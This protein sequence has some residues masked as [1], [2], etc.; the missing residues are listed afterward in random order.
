MNV[1]LGGGKDITKQE[2]VF[3]NILDAADKRKLWTVFIRLDDIAGSVGTKKLEKFV[4][5]F[6]QTFCEFSRRKGTQIPDIEIQIS[7][8]TAFQ[9]ARSAV[10]SF[11]ISSSQYT[12][13]V[14]SKPRKTKGMHSLHYSIV[15]DD[16]F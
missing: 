5:L 15:Y 3:E 11:L 12:A 9:V 14:Y 2:K 13:T 6:V 8:R 16:A 1:K 4:K 7:D 10:R